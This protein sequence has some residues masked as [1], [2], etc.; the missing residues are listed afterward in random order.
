MAEKRASPINSVPCTCWDFLA[1]YRTASQRGAL[2]Q[3]GESASTPVKKVQAQS[4]D[5]PEPK[6]PM[7]PEA[8]VVVDPYSSGKYLLIE[9]ERRGIPIIGVRSSTKL[10]TQF[11]RSHVANS[12]FWVEMLEFEDFAG[13]AELVEALKALPYSIV[14]VF[15]GSEPGVELADHVANALAMP[16]ANSLELLEARKNKAE[17][18]EALRRNGVPAA[19]QFKSGNLEELL[20]WAEKRNEWPV[21]AKPTGGASSDGVYF[22]K[23]LEDLRLAHRNIIG[24]CNPTGKVNSEIALQEYLDGDEYIVDTVSYEGKHMLVAMWMYTKCKGMPWDSQAIVPM[25]NILLASTGEKQDQLVDYVFKVLDA[26]GLRYGPCHTEVMFTKRGPVLVEVNARLHG[27]QG[28]RLI[29]LSTGISKATYAADVILGKGDLFHKLYQEERPG[30]YLYPRLRQCV[31]LVLVSSAQGYLQTD[32][33][34]MLSSLLL[35]S[36]VEILPAVEQGGFINR[37]RDLPTTA[38]TVLMVHES[39]EQIKADTAKI[40]ELEETGKLYEVSQE[41]LATSKPVTPA[42]RRAATLESQDGPQAV[43]IRLDS[44]EKMDAL[45]AEMNRSPAK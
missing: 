45:W 13:I 14:G 27:L 28:P 26:V 6:F 36:V 42:R 3:R 2:T 1:I 16:T 34:E 44:F 23:T 40:R 8:A 32:I 18:Q 39:I 41:P 12:G 38:G 25:Q 31:C 30:R 17:M 22:C 7:L 35:P 33:K 4:L 21:V 19:E 15:G 29:E 11:L 37:T 5:E 9:L 43:R 10:G 24:A 20:A